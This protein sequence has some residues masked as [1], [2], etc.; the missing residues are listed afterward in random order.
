MGIIKD[1]TEHKK[2]EEALKESEKRH[3]R[4]IETADE[5]IWEMDVDF[6]TTHVNQKMANMLGYSSEEMIGMPVTLFMFEEDLPDQEFCVKRRRKGISDRYERRLKHK[7]GN[8]IW[9][10]VSAT[11][12][13]DKNG[14]FAGSFAMFTDITKRKKAEKELEKSK[15]KLETIIHGSPV[16]TF[17][18]DNNHRVLYWNKAIEEYSGLTAN[19]VIGTQNH[20]KAFYDKK[21][22]LLVDLM[23]DKNIEGISKW[24]SEYSKSK[25]IDGAYE[26]EDFFPTMGII[27]VMHKK[28]RWLRGTA[29]IIKDESGK[30]I[31]AME[32]LEDI[33]GR[34]K[35]E[36]A[37]KSSE[38]NLRNIFD[39][40]P[41][42]IAIMSLDGKIIDVNKAVLK[43]HGFS[44]KEELIGKD[45]LYLVDKEY[46]KKVAEKLEEMLKKGYVNDV[47]LVQLKKD[48]QKV[49]TIISATLLNDDAGN[50]YAF[51]SMGQDITERKKAEEQVKRANIYNRG[52]IESSLDPLVTIGLEGKITDVNSSTEDVTGY[53]RKQLIGTDFSD[54]FTEPEKAREGY[55]RVFKEGIVRDYELEI[56]HKDGY[57]TP[58]SYNAS[59]YE[60]ENNNVIGVFAAARDVS[61]RKIAEK[62]L[63]AAHANLEI[64]VKERTKELEEAYTALSESEEKFRE[65]FNNAN[66]TITL[67][68][69]TDDGRPGKFIEVND[70]ATRNLGYS[71]DELLN[72]TPLDIIQKSL[73]EGP[74][75]ALKILE[76]GSSKFETLHVAK[77]GSK[78][79][80]EVNTHLFKL[81]GKDVILGISRDISERKKAE[82]ELKKSEAYYKTI[83]ENT[84]TASV[85]VEED[86]TISLV[87]A[88]FENLGGYPKEEVENKKKWQEF[89]SDDY[90]QIMDEYHNL[91]RINPE[92]TPR[93]Y[94]FKFIDKY[95]N[96]KDVLM[97]IAIIPGTKKSLAS[98]L[99]ITDQKIAENALRES[100]AQLRI[101][102]DLA[103]IVSWEYD[104]ESDMFTFDDH[105]YALYGTT[106]KEAGGT[107]MSPEEYARRFIPPEESFVV[108]EET[109]KA[110][111]TDDPDFFG[112][113]EHSI[114]R[115]DGE[116]RFITVRYGVIKDENGKTIKTYGANQD[117]TERKKAQESIIKS[118]NYLDKI[119]N[120]IADPVI[121]KD[122]QHRWVLLNDAYCQFMGYSREELLGKSD[123]EFFPS[124]EADIFW[125]KDEEVLKTGK[126]NVNEEEFTDSNNN[127]HIIVTKKTLYEDISGKK[128]IVGVIRDITD[129][130]NAEKEL[131]NSNERFKTVMDSLDAIVYVADMNTYEILYVNKYAKE[132]WGDIEGKKCWQFI[133][134]GQTGPCPF[135]TNEMLL[136]ENGN[137]TGVY[138]WE[139]QNTINKRW[140]ECRDSAISWIDGRLVRMEVATDITNR[141]KLENKSKARSKS[142]NVLNKVI[143][144]A[145]RSN[146]LQSL[147]EDVLDLTLELM[148]F[149]GGGIY[150]ID[151]DTKVAKLNYFKG[152]PEDFIKTVDNIQIDK[153]PY[154]NVFINGKS[155]FMDR[156]DNIRPEYS[157]WH[158]KS[159]ASVPIYSKDKIIGTLNLGNLKTHNFTKG[160]KKLIKSIGREIGNTIAR[161]ITEEEMKQL[162]KDLKRSNE[163]LE[164]FAYVASHDLQEPLRTIASFTQLL[165]IRYKGKFDS[166]ADEFMD[167]IVEAA[168]RMKEQIIGLLEY[169]R[170]ARTDEKFQIVD[171]NY[172]LENAINSLKSSIKEYNAKV[173]YDELPSIMGESNQLLRVFINLISNALKF[174]NEDKPP[175]I[176]I[177]SLKSE[178]NNEYIFS[179]SDNGIGIEEQY[180]ERIFV[181]FQR[182]HTREKYKG[183]GIGLSIVKKIIE[184][185]GGR[186]WVESEYGKGSTFYFTLPIID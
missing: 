136:D 51:L 70:A 184:R 161:L 59:V 182:L 23:L 20:W 143:L 121:V 28:G 135:C 151:E 5:G 18:I 126:E 48:G 83:F 40:S 39:S 36:E 96:V 57:I 29:S 170:V 71:R 157:K 100:E 148:N 87:N 76:D 34:K 60:D 6:N 80:V 137:L 179:I 25:I 112:Q 132:L 119:I 146:N 150:L 8:E 88:E 178:E 68:E 155:M 52:L 14:K 37:L 124:D 24:Y 129:L 185:H 117:I 55:Q 134:T 180:M 103:K 78:I 90:I 175:R 61:E 149:E 108:A 177:T 95:G 42:D 168:K 46:H 158:L 2:A 30:I 73:E 65:L 82:E 92:I 4:I 110:L 105:F 164:R 85:I 15:K 181:I 115:A 114:I 133:Q 130:K 166:D 153:Y 7:N 145:N 156:Y 81:K 93:N 97:T 144:A 107:Q 176:H 49:N 58:V 111:K 75:N 67:G 116:K 19:E 27:P 186:I 21:R 94:E 141:K 12:L 163:E 54:Y 45:M 32:I 98:L 26:T 43:L 62:A 79:P 131:I 35:A 56:K 128:Y 99:D 69:L 152:L 109:A 125:R 91:R 174:R 77:D 140:Y 16:L 154:S 104:V 64:K 3:R 120:S 11:P 160:E 89:V 162:I 31:G 22:P 147:L 86:S 165:E 38:Q 17:I 142:L 10:A 9:M 127:L 102:M 118:R 74:Q 167:Y 66:D 173:T 13:N 159:G 122:E 106:V 1:I 33:T 53:S 171:S 138:V 44:R 139:F 101:A 169:S 63:T 41:I 50:P 84:G 72:M 47:E 183:T 172:I 123:Y 113:V